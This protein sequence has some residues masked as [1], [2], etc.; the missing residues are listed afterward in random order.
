[1]CFTAFVVGSSTHLAVLSP[2]LMAWEICAALTVAKK[3][4]FHI[5][6]ATLP[7]VTIKP[8]VAS[9]R[10]LTCFNVWWIQE[11]WERLNNMFLRQG[12]SPVTN[13]SQLDSAWLRPGT[14]GCS[15]MLLDVRNGQLETKCKDKPLLLPKKHKLRLHNSLQRQNIH[16]QKTPTTSILQWI[17]GLE[18][19]ELNFIQIEQVQ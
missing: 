3:L 8:L 6:S 14:L 2:C 12:A 16:P 11:Q 19:Y 9:L 5:P 13:C 10:I 18:D 4:D 7:R 17:S 15:E 1:M